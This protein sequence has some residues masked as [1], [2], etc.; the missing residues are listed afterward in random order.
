MS[1]E[2]NKVLG[3]KELPIFPLPLVL[4]PFEFLPLHIFEPRYRELLT[5]IQMAKNLFGISRFES[6]N[7]EK[8]RPAID[9]IGCVAEV[10]DSQTLDDGR[11]NILTIGVIRYRIMGYIDSPKPYPIADVEFF[12]DDDVSDTTSAAN[13]VFELFRRIAKA[14]HSASGEI[15]Q[16]PEI[17]QAPPE[18]LSFLISA[19]FNLENDVKY[20]ILKTRSTSKRLG[21]VKKILQESLVKL[22]ETTKINKISRTNGHSKKD[23][24]LDGI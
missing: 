10:N 6:T 23:L 4:L 2:F 9:S 12:E 11:S 8:D 17:P 20:E 24:D 14:A 3:I 21:R 13:D 22:E 18:Q 19:A 7:I 16:F 5:D 15:G 1:E